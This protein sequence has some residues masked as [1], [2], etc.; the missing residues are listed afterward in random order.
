MK[1]FEAAQNYASILKKL[2]QIVEVND[3][4]IGAS[5]IF[6]KFFF[7][8]EG[9]GFKKYKVMRV[10]SSCSLI[11]LKETNKLEPMWKKLF[12]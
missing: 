5:I 9:E 7:W 3:Q 8:K 1:S 4:A 2:T 6:Y 11:T 12:K 10:I